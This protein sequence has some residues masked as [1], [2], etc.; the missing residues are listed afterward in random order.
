MRS[1]TSGLRAGATVAL[2]GTVIAGAAMPVAAVAGDYGS[3]DA[4]GYYY[5]PCARA[6]TQRGTGGALTGAALG[7]AIGSSVAAR[8]NRTEGAVL[9]GVVGALA[10]ASVG[11]SSAACGSAQGQRQTGYYGRE[12]NRYGY[13]A[14][15]SHP[16]SRGSA[17]GY[18]NNGYGYQGGYGQGYDQGYYQGGYSQPGYGNSYDYGYDRS[19]VSQSSGRD[20]CTLAESPIYLPDGRVQKR[21]VRVCLDANGQY[22]VVE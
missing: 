20:Q 18:N 19:P 3:R 16:G 10:G 17:Y 9:G 11:R 2:I 14:P 12:D 5:D 21:F 22:Q 6:T 1:F 8:G 4:N 7:A 13:Q 15:Y